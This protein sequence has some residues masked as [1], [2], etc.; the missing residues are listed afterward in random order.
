MTE[1]G[2]T[3]VEDL[4]KIPAQRKTVDQLHRL[5]NKRVGSPSGHINLVTPEN[6]GMVV[7]CTR[8][9]RSKPGVYTPRAA[10]QELTLNH[11]EFTHG[12]LVPEGDMT[13][14][15]EYIIFRRDNGDK[16]IGATFKATDWTEDQRYQAE[17]AK[18]NAL[19]RE[20]K[21]ISERWAQGLIEYV[22]RLERL[23]QKP[24]ITEP[25]S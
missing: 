15:F 23:D 10:I 7:L 1:A 14:D 25:G 22:Q 13:Y 4:S 12:L 17:V 5:I 8:R 19:G 21:L 20:R 2:N 9:A 24:S 18:E 3:G 6:T 11:T 16:V